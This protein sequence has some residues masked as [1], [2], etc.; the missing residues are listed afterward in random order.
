MATKTEKGKSRPSW[1]RGLKHISF[2][3]CTQIAVAPFVGAWVETPPPPVFSAAN[4]V[5]PFVGAWV[6]TQPFRAALLSAHVAPFVGA[7]VETGWHNYPT[8]YNIVAPFVGAWVETSRMILYKN[9]VIMSRP[10]WARG[11]KLES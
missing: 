6:E 1:A 10:S 3:H 8:R 7:W 2:Y 4:P 5:A 9:G 11:L